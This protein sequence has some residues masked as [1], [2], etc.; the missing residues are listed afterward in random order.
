ML[1]DLIAVVAPVFITVAV[2]YAWIKSGQDFPEAFVTRFVALV[3]SPCLVFSALTSAD[4]SP[5]ALAEIAGAMAACYACLCFAGWAALKMFGLSRQIYLPALM[6]PNIGNMGLP[7]CYYAFGEEGLALAV[8]ILATSIGAMWTV[9]AWI[10]S[11]T[12]SL[13]KVLL[14]PALIAIAIA[15]AMTVAGA[16]PP[17][18]IAN[19]TDLIGDASIP[20]MLL[21]LGVS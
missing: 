7:I 13:R 16:K 5:N 19:T 4:I 18:W 1:P 12:F 3:T 9:G 14:N 15:V 20:L 2:G 11:G 21:T 17:K 10:S 8:A 6:F